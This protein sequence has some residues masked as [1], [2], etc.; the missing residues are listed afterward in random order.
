MRSWQRVYCMLPTH[1][2]GESDV[3]RV[4]TRAETHRGSS[5]RARLCVGNSGRPSIRSDRRARA[6][7]PG[8]PSMN[9]GRASRRCERPRRFLGQA[10]ANLPRKASQAFEVGVQ[11]ALEDPQQRGNHRHVRFGS[12]AADQPAR[13]YP[14]DTYSSRT[15]SWPGRD[16][17]GVRID[18]IRPRVETRPR[19]VAISAASRG[20][21]GQHAGGAFFQLALP[22][23]GNSPSTATVTDMVALAVDCALR[24]GAPER[25]IE[26]DGAHHDGSRTHAHANSFYRP[27]SVRAK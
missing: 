19:R 8:A 26:D 15:P 10:G 24:R 17:Q 13:S 25:T 14:S 1:V 12:S 22:N 6:A 2:S 3:V 27:V 16:G 4:A 11:G 21:G 20:F 5:S 23:V 18:A 9:R 7:R